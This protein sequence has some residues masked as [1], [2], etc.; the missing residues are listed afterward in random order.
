[1]ALIARD[2]VTTSGWLLERPVPIAIISRPVEIEGD[3][4]ALYPDPYAPSHAATAA[5]SV[6]E[7]LRLLGRAQSIDSSAV[8]AF[9]AASRGRPARI[10]LRVLLRSRP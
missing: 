8:A 7:A 10:P 9:A 4:V 3:T 6:F 2:T 5:R 1:M